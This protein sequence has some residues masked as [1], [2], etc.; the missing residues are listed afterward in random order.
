MSSVS[1]VKYIWSF[2]NISHQQ[3]LSFIKLMEIL[4]FAK[5]AKSEKTT[6]KLTLRKLISTK[7]S[8]RKVVSQQE[9]LNKLNEVNKQMHSNKNRIRHLIF[10]FYIT[11]S[12]AILR[13]IPIYQTLVYFMWQ[14]YFSLYFIYT[15]IYIKD[16]IKMRQ[17]K[18]T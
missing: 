18:K 1:Q 7:I 4:L 2:F 10:Q 16:C 3:L 14:L 11:F 6:Q 5:S 15:Y 12:S 17:Q 9:F 13:R 8:I